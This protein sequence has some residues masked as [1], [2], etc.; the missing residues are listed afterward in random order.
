[1]P[2]Q[3]RPKCG[4]QLR[5]RP[6]GELCERIA[7]T[8]K[9]RCQAHGG[10]STGAKSPEGKAA[11]R[12]NAL[13]HGVYLS[14]IGACME[15]LGIPPEVFYAVPQTTD[16]SNELAVARNQVIRYATLLSEGI[17]E[18][19]IGATGGISVDNLYQQALLTVRALAKSQQEIKPGG[20]IGGHL[21]FTIKVSDGAKA[22]DTDEVPNLTEDAPQDDEE[23]MGVLTPKAEPPKRSS[24]YDEDE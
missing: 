19:S 18:I 2:T 9:T 8:G 16:L 5:G 6:A 20:D 11:Q 13:K 14:T 10:A 1:M 24:G 21:T 4:A 7:M 22:E 15:K 3:Q 17:N 12:H 23:P